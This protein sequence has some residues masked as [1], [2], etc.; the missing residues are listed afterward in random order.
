MRD[1]KVLITGGLGFIGQHVAGLLVEQGWHVL[2]FDNLSPQ[3]HGA[4]PQLPVEGLLQHPRVEIYRGDVRQPEDWRRV[5]PDVRCVVHLASET[6]TAQSMYEISRYAGTNVGGISD[7]LNYLANC[8]HNIQKII[9][10]SSRAIEKCVLVIRLVRTQP[11]SGA[12]NSELHRKHVEHGFGGQH[13]G[14]P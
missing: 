7:L 6:G 2:L 1:G 11:A 8:R 10:A 13:S 9:L 14:F 5:L 3:V 4:V 12:A